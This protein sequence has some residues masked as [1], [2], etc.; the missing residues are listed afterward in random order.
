MSINDFKELFSKFRDCIR[1][2]VEGGYKAQ[3]SG[4]TKHGIAAECIRVGLKTI[5][6]LKKVYDY[7]I[8]KSQ[9]SINAD[10][11]RKDAYRYATYA[12]NTG[13]KVSCKWLKS[14]GLCSGI[15]NCEFFKKSSIIPDLPFSIE[16]LKKHL[17]AKYS[18]GGKARLLM[19]VVR[20]IRRQQIE[21]INAREVIFIGMRGIAEKVYEDIK[22]ELIPKQIERLVSTLRKEKVLDVK[23]EGKSG[24]GSKKSNGYHWL[25]WKAE[26]PL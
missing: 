4:A 1:N 24:W 2:E 25:S 26:E 12:I 21:N 13:Y 14:E 9:E 18:E 7:W 11:V 23:E 8:E 15:E 20:A 5:E 22:A 19:A 3:H 16:Q 6:D 17:E 10:E